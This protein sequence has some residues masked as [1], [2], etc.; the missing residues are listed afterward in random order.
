LELWELPGGVRT[1][2][3]RLR[4][5]VVSPEYSSFCGIQ[6]DSAGEYILVQTAS[7]TDLF[8]ASNLEPLFKW[9]APATGVRD[10]WRFSS[11]TPEIRQLYDGQTDQAIGLPLRHPDEVL[12]SRASEDRNLAVTACGDKLVRLWDLTTGQL[13]APP[14]HFESNV[15]DARFTPDRSHLLIVS[16]YIAQLYPIAP[17]SGSVEEAETLATISSG[18]SYNTNG[19]LNDV[20]LEEFKR[21]LEI[22]PKKKR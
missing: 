4:D 14:W 7:T 16:D 19:F 8:R 5:A 21:L 1:G 2:A 22:Y 20:S 12:L 17:F 10:I 6:F 18:L 9:V 11:S 15:V 13:I 3:V